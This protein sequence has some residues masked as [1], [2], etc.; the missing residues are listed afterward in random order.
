[1]KTVLVTGSTGYIGHLIA[2][3]LI[4]NYKVK[5]FS[6]RNVDTS[7]ELIQCDLLD[8][9]PITDF[10]ILI[11]VAAIADINKCEEYPEIA[12]KVNIEGTRKLLDMAK[13]NNAEKVIYIS[14]GSIYAPTLEPLREESEIKPVNVYSET[15]FRAEELVKSF[16]N[17]VPAIILRLFFPYGPNTHPQKL[18]SRLIN[19]LEG[20][21]PIL[22]NNCNRPLINPIYINDLVELIKLT[23][24]SNE[25]NYEVFNAGG[26]ETVNIKQLGEIIG[27]VMEKEVKFEKTLNESPNYQA[28][29]VKAKEKLGFEPL[30]KLEKGIRETIK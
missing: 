28:L 11:H 24:I 4:G 27:K 16:S 8:E 12:R 22:L 17:H 20:G 10:D 5:G 9:L 21:K 23:L 1:M 13:E 30:T 7:F 25:S 26:G 19:R 14:T 18:V 29:I 6:R 15:K 3:E 2:T